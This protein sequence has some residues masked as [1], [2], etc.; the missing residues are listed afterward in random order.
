MKTN[1][2]T[3]S[4]RVTEAEEKLL[5]AYLKQIGHTNYSILKE[6]V[7][8]LLTAAQEANL[9]LSDTPPP[10]PPIE[11][12]RVEDESLDLSD[13]LGQPMTEVNLVSLC[14]DLHRHL[15]SKGIETEVTASGAIK[16]D[17]ERLTTP[18]VLPF[19]QKCAIE[20]SAL[21]PL[22]FKSA[23]EVMNALRSA[24]ITNQRIRA[25]IDGVELQS[26]DYN[27]LVPFQS[28]TDSDKFV[29]YDSVNQVVTDLDYNTYRQSTNVQ[30]E[31]IKARISF[32]PY[33]PKILDFKNDE[34]GRPCNFINIYRKPLWQ[35]S[36]DI[37]VEEGRKYK[38]SPLFF[39]F[40]NHLF[41][42]KECQEFV[43]DWLH[44]ALTDR[45]ETYLVLNGAKGIGKNLFSELLC[46]PLMGEKNHKIAHPSALT[47]DFNAILA[48]SRMIVS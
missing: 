34:Y 28:I 43:F 29:L 10:M 24:I 48:D 2:V 44:Y 18:K 46:K 31:V 47:S 37:G 17:G 27:G 32:N 33:S 7:N 1:Y 42:D 15:K 8:G 9:D 41:P 19:L 21:Q 16:I 40:M 26:Y 35:L 14:D 23:S 5:R 36:D 38:P 25:R 11:D 12:D 20:N 6:F 45:C 39:E 13:L 22:L 30:I 3:L 4:T